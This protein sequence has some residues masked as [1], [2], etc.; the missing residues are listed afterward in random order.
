MSTPNIE[1]IR[2]RLG[3]TQAQMAEELGIK[4]PTLSEYERGESPV[5]GPVLKLLEILDQRSKRNK[6]K[7]RAA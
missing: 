7:K 6:G 4:Q 3:L 1:A 2:K 5:S